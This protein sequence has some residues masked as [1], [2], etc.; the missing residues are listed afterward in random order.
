MRN[1]QVL[2]QEVFD[3][4]T[5]IYYLFVILKSLHSISVKLAQ[6][7]LKLAFVKHCFYI[8]QTLN[9]CYL[10]TYLTLQDLTCSWKAVA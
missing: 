2:E 5:V 1:L 7:S 4:T 9:K 10:L 6:I 8:W 3:V